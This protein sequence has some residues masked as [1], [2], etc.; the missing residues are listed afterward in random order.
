LQEL[1]CMNNGIFLLLGSNQGRSLEIL[2]RT[3][4]KIESDVGEI[5]VRSAVYKTAAWGFTD[6]P[7]FYNQVLQIQS[8]L[9]PEKLLAEL[10]KIEASLGRQ[11]EEKWGP[12]T[13]DID[14][15]FYG[16][17]ML[18]TPRLTLPHPGIPNRRFV[19]VPLTEIA[20]GWQHPVLEKTMSEL[21]EACD[22]TLAV[23]KITPGTEP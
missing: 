3:S 11:R 16:R 1:K 15:L 8:E 7:D 5:L 14:L 10:M 2:Q 23:E 6:Q 19:L 13:I 21:L 22:D 12:R 17:Q 9:P 4:E 20:P 18:N